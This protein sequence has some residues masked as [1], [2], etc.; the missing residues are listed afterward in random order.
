METI[1]ED[2][3]EYKDDPMGL[4]TK[5]APK[6]LKPKPSKKGGQKHIEARAQTMMEAM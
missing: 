6:I 4:T 2:E 5:K 1:P 3:L